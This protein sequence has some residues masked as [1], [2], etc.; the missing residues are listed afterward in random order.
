[1]TDREA[2]LRKLAVGD[3]F[4]GRSPNSASLICLITAIDNSTIYA[5]RITTQDD[6]QFNRRTGIELGDVPSRID[7]VAPFPAVL[8][9]VFLEMDRKGQV[10]AKMFRNG[11]EPGLDKYKLTPSEHRALLVIDEHIEANQI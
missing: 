6:H 11:V 7:C 2:T 1:M 3:M 5:R 8:Y 4:H 9:E 10:L